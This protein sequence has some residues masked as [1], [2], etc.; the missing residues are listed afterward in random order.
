MGKPGV[1]VCMLHWRG[2]YRS[3]SRSARLRKARKISIF[4]FFARV[5]VS[6]FLS[7][8]LLSSLRNSDKPSGDKLIWVYFT[9]ALG[10]LFFL[11]KSRRTTVLREVDSVFLLFL[12]ESFR[13]SYSQDRHF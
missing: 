13:E 8:L 7:F 6:V 3:V 12:L 10:F 9:A 11:K 4:F 5:F 2:A 1:T